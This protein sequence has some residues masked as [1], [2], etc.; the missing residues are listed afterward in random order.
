M[1]G[2]ATLMKLTA[3]NLSSKASFL[4]TTS[5]TRTPAAVRRSAELPSTP[6]RSARRM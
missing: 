3:I 1:N 4:A 6:R 2:T 5:G